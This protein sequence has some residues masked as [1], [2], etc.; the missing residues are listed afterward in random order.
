LAP[1]VIDAQINHA[2]RVRNLVVHTGRH[3]S[4][5]EGPDLWDHMTVIREL[6]VRFVLTAFGYRGQY[7]SHMGG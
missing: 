2:I 3:P 6:V 5:D 1:L 7:T 4:V